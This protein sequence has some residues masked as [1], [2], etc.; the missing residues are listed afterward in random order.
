[1]PKTRRCRLPGQHFEQREGEH[2]FKAI[3]QGCH[4]AQGQG[5]HGAGAYPALGQ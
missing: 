5:A 4:M 1:M 3:C 2:L